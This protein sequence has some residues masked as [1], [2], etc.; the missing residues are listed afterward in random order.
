MKKL[1]KA[2]RKLVRDLWTPKK[3]SDTLCLVP[4]SAI[5]RPFVKRVKLKTF[6]DSVN[7]K[8]LYEQV[9]F[10]TETNLLWTLRYVNYGNIVQI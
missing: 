10:N 2:P 4:L 1:M 3:H 8:Q 7:R 5:H 6:T 9:S